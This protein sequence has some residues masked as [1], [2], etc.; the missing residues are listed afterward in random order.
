MEEQLALIFS[1]LLFTIGVFGVLYRR[2]AVVMLMCIELCLSSANLAFAGFSKMNSDISGQIFAFFV[3][4][5]AAAEAVVGLAIVVAIS[6]LKDT[7]NVDET[8]ALKG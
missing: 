4:S 7:V 3:I 2:N 1:A 6:R 8:Q 5:V